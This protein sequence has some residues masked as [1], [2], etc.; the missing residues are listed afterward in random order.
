MRDE[1]VNKRE[2]WGPCDLGTHARQE[3]LCIY[4]MEK[5]ITEICTVKNVECLLHTDDRNDECQS[6]A[7]TGLGR[8]KDI[9]TTQSQT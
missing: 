4:N 5:T 2:G 3:T 7:G 8:P 1:E 6:L 9:Q